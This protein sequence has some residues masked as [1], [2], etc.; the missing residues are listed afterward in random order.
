MITRTYTEQS[1][2]LAGPNCLEFLQNGGMHCQLN[3]KEGCLP[4]E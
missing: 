1:G 4:V 3:C 2:M